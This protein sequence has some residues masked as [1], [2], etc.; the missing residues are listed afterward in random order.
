MSR[1]GSPLM[2]NFLSFLLFSVYEW[3]SSLY[4]VIS[5]LAFSSAFWFSRNNVSMFGVYFIFVVVLVICFIR[6]VL[7]VSVILLMFITIGGTFVF[8]CCLAFLLTSVLWVKV[9]LFRCYFCFVTEAS[10]AALIVRVHE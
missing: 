7:I 3:Y 1:G 9:V 10:R 2:T 4:L 8:F 5:S 6:S